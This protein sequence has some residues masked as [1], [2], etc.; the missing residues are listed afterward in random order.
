[1]CICTHTH[2][3]IYR[4][5]CTYHMYIRVCVF[6]WSYHIYI[7]RSDFVPDQSPFAMAVVLNGPAT[8]TSEDQHTCE[9]LAGGGWR[10][11][12]SKPSTFPWG[13]IMIYPIYWGWMGL[14]MVNDGWWWLIMIDDGDFHSHGDTPPKK[15]D[16]DFLTEDPNRKWMMTGGTPIS[17]NPHSE[18]C[19][20]FSNP[21]GQVGQLGGVGINP[22]VSGCV[23]F[24]FS[25]QDNVLAFFKHVWLSGSQDYIKDVSNFCCILS[26]AKI[27]YSRGF[28]ISKRNLYTVT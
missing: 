16:G 5:T 15:L 6:S 17:G 28:W 27:N 1:M 20:R 26:W 2:T 9:D 11:L 7:K 8:L 25:W 22:S 3:Y 14:M 23:G 12:T 19:D 13:Y 4:Y 21:N 18:W 10:R 24:M